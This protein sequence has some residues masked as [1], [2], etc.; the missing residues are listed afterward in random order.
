MRGTSKVPRT[1]KFEANR[2]ITIRNVQFQDA[3]DITSIIREVGWFEHLKSES[4]QTTADRVRQHI[5]LCLV[6]DSHSALIA[7]NE[8][9]KV[10]GYSSMYYLPFFFYPDRKDM[11]L[12]FLFLQK[13]AD[14]VLA[15]HC[16]NKLLQKHE[17]TAVRAY[18]SLTAA[19]VNNTS[20]M[21]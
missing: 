5:S 9:R 7:E 21:K 10:I 4:A 16:W 15:P 20:A 3:E 6:D 11:F 1:V 2:D 19:L 18:H 17:D 8:K 12:N 13:L 14:K